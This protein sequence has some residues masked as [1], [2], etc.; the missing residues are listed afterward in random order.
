MFIYKNLNNIKF[1]PII[2]WFFLIPNQNHKTY[3]LEWKYSQYLGKKQVE[4]V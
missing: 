2:G 4:S 1:W 3:K